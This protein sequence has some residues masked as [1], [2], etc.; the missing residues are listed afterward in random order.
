MSQ[1][2]E[3]EDKGED[4]PQLRKVL[5]MLAAGGGGIGALMPKT[6][7]NYCVELCS[8]LQNSGGS[9]ILCRCL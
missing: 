5:Q 8:S 2:L 3:A 9:Q 4:L 1:T 7:I 6:S